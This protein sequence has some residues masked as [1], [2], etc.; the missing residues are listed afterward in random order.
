MK[1]EY[2]G[3]SCFRISSENG[4]KIVTDPYTKVGYELPAD[5]TADIVALSHG[6]FDHNHLTGVNGVK[7]VLDKAGNYTASGIPFE[8]ITTDHDPVGGAL[9]GKNIVFKMT[10]DGTVVCHMG[11]IGERCTEKLLAAIGKVDVLLIPVGGTYT[12]DAEQAYEYVRKINPRIAIPMHY[13]PRDG[14]LD[15]ASADGFLN[16]FGTVYAKK[17]GVCVPS[18]TEPLSEKTK[19]VFMERV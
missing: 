13:K 4:V 14:A 15:I 18:E 1:I 11:D 7:T 12:I 8:G 2:F 6:H 10:V 3:H 9:R 19:I 16:L 17:K 5:L